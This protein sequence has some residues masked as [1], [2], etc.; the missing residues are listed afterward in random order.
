MIDFGSSNN[1][2]VHIGF[3]DLSYLN[4]L[5]AFSVLVRFRLK[6]NDDQ[7]N[8]VA[9][10]GNLDYGN[11]AGWAIRFVWSAADQW[12]VNFVWGGAGGAT[13]IGGVLA[14]TAGEWHTLGMVFSG[15]GTYFAVYIDEASNIGGTASNVMAD[16]SE[17]FAIGGEYDGDPDRG[18]SWD[19]DHLIVYPGIALI[20]DDYDAFRAG[21][22]P[23]P[24]DAKF[25]WTGQYAPGRN[26]L[27]HASGGEEAGTNRNGTP[28]Q[29]EEAGFPWHWPLVGMY[30][31]ASS[32]EA[33]DPGSTDEGLMA[34]SMYEELTGRGRVYFCYELDLPDDTKIR[35]SLESLPTEEGLYENI[36]D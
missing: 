19:I 5:V 36:L 16:S 6:A 13:T 14:L 26:E 23:R 9:L 10:C 8:W 22:M 4:E 12:V 34:T 17:G 18:G 31:P 7:G 24:G 11:V 29:T 28:V 21:M 30:R 15:S 20:S 25:W 3:G 1:N 2:D 35:A 32:G 27:I 33:S